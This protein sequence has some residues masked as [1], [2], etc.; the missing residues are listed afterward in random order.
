GRNPE[1]D[2]RRP[3]L[4]GGAGHQPTPESSEMKTKWTKKALDKLADG[5]VALRLVEQDAVE[6]CVLRINAS[7][8]VDPW[9]FRESRSEDERT[10]FVDPLVVRYKIN[11]DEGTVVVTDV[12]FSKRRG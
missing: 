8:A 4:Y 12:A 10:W 5:Y 11:S 7:L 3:D 2:P 9:G 1:T 6:A